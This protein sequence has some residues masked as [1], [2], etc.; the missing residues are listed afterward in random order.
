MK[1]LTRLGTETRS[2]V[3]SLK[4]VNKAAPRTA[5]R[6]GQLAGAPVLKCGEA[7]PRRGPSQFVAWSFLKCN[8]LKP[9]L[10]QFMLTQDYCPRSYRSRCRPCGE[11]RVPLRKP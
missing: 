7:Q 1:S 3:R 2:L 4:P 9:L 5:P 6:F 10:L 11:L 8:K